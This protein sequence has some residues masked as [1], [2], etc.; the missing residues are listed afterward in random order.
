MGTNFYAV[1]KKP[2]VHNSMHIGKASA[3]W[4]FLFHEIN[5]GH[6][7]FDNDLEIHTYEQWKEYLYGHKDIVILNEY[8][9]KVSL[10]EFFALVD[11]KQKSEH[12]RN[13]VDCKNIDGYRF[14]DRNFL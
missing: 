1:K 2:A 6:C 10:N 7:S 11:E 13:F 14:S 5:K 3:G 12:N 4:K 8:D 9:E